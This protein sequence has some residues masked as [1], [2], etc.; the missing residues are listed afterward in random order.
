MG[1]R[2][3]V[4][5][6]ATIL[7]VLKLFPAAHGERGFAVKRKEPGRHHQGNGLFCPGIGRHLEEETTVAAVLKLA[8]CAWS[9]VTTLGFANQHRID[10]RDVAAR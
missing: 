7:A 6:S 8:A 9:N 10:D 4:H 1:C 5:S 2:G 3:R